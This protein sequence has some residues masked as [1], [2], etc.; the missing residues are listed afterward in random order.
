MEYHHSDPPCLISVVVPAK[1][2]DRC[3][4]KLIQNL[5]ALFSELG[6]PHE[7]IIVDDG[8]SDLTFDVVRKLR[9]SIGVVKGL[10]F[11][12][13][14]GKESALLAGLHAC[15]GDAVITI[16]ADHQHPPTL[17]PDM[18]RKWKDG[19]SVVH[20]VKTHDPSHSWL[21][22]QGIRIFSAL[23][24]WLGGIDVQN[25][26]DFKLLDRKVVGVLVSRLREHR[27]FF[28]ALSNW[29]GFRQENVYFSV[30]A[31]ESGQ[32]KWSIPSLL[33]LAIAGVVSFTS[34]P[35]RL[36]TFLGVITLIFGTIVTIETI[37]AWFYGFSVSGFATLEITIL[38]IGSFI[39]IS[40]GIV[41]EYI[42]NIYE[43]VKGRPGYIVEEKLGFDPDQEE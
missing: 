10:R 42:A 14:F 34:A 43:E 26:S 39:M 28:R 6:I 37:W 36:V 31:R 24:S 16:D 15:K 22:R 38:L 35:L 20:A 40:L 30:Q 9:E 32:S 7:I 29:V 17:I 12:R 1:D 33:D 13:N 41:G 2:E 23:L 5:H 25:S 18:L 8:S 21:P 27:R 4:E 11:S 3:I 19:A